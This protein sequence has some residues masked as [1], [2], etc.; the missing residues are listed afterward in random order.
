MSNNNPGCLF[1]FLSFFFGKQNY[2]QQQDEHQ[3]LL[4]HKE[5]NT[6]EYRYRSKYFLTKNEYYFYKSLKQIADKLGYTILSKVRMADLVEPVISPYSKE[7][8]YV[9]S[10]IKAKHVDFILANPENLK[11]VLLIELDDNS[12]NNSERDEFCDAVYK[13]AGYKILHIRG[14]AGLEEAIKHA[15]EQ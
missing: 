15:L 5:D 14:A 6:I 2:V 13:E 10:K 11:A 3:P 9:F 1:G 4:P 7:Y 12:H 8:K